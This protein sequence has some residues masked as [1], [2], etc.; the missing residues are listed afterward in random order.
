MFGKL[1]SLLAGTP[2]A[3]VAEIARQGAIILD[4]RTSAEF[5]G[6]HIAGS[7]NIPIEALSRSLGKLKD[8]DR[9][10]ITCCASGS[11]S[12]VAVRLLK[13]QGYTNVYNGG[14]WRG[15]KSKIGK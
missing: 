3:D 14:G 12:G 9:P 4:V 15:L 7:L 8:K 11:R 1:K 13:A 2:Q 6:G 10:I 5:A